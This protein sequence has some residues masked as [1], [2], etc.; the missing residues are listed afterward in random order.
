MR[1]DARVITTKETPDTIAP[2]L[3]WDRANKKRKKKSKINNH[4]MDLHFQA[5]EAGCPG[6]QRG[7]WAPRGSWRRPAPCRTPRSSD[8]HTPCGAVALDCQDGPVQCRRILLSN[9]LFLCILSLEKVNAKRD[10]NFLLCWF[11]MRCYFGSFWRPK[12]I[13]W[14]KWTHFRY[15]SFSILVLLARVTL[16]P[17]KTIY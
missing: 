4:K 11:W 2:I 14:K 13:A 7:S 17:M 3:S 8:R 5:E 9:S 12:Y 1:V 10:S 6:E 15:F 16:Q